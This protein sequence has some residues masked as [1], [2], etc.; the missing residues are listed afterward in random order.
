MSRRTDELALRDMRE[1]ALAA[2]ETLENIRFNLARMNSK[3]R[4][5]AKVLRYGPAALRCD[6]IR[7]R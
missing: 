4:A 1:Y 7:T 2:V 6:R 5:P 3:R